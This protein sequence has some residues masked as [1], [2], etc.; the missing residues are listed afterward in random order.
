MQDQDTKGKTGTGNVDIKTTKE[1]QNKLKR[2]EK[3]GNIKEHAVDELA[4]QKYKHSDSQPV[5]STS[6]A[7]YEAGLEPETIISSKC[8]KHHNFSVLQKYWAGS[9]CLKGLEQQL[10]Q[11]R[12]RI[13]ELFLRTTHSMLSIET[14]YGKLEKSRE[15]CQWHP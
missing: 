13:L 1:N 12:Y 7:P 10:F 3:S 2:K 8:K 11:R 6:N 5:P 4:P 14:K 9:T 15:N